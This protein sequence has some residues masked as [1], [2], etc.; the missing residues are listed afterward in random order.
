V[1]ARSRPLP[2]PAASAPASRSCS[3]TSCQR[4]PETGSPAGLVTNHLSSW[5][6]RV[7]SANPTPAS[8]V[9]A[10]IA[11]QSKLSAL[12]RAQRTAARTREL[13][14]GRIRYYEAERLAS[15]PGPTRGNAYVTEWDPATGRV[16]SWA[17]SYDHSGNVT[18]V[19]PKMINGQQVNG[20]H[21]PPTGQ[22]LGR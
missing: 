15:K 13:P 18:R 22:E 20:P 5:V 16:R 21:Y 12:Q 4:S 19:H 14:D 8:S 10:G 17:E 11:L 2:W 1:A 7:R 6:R 9:N 3:C